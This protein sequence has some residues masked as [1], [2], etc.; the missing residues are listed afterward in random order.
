[1]LEQATIIA[2]LVLAIWYT[3]Q[4]GEI[5]GF[6]QRWSHWKAAPALFDCNVCMTP[7]WGSALYWLIPWDKIKMSE[8]DIYAWPIVVVVAMGINAALNKLSPKDE[9]EI[10]DKRDKRSFFDKLK[11]YLDS[12]NWKKVYDS[13]DSEADNKPYSFEVDTDK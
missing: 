11:E 6:V 13:K 7:W 9:I 8:A 4:E 2:F 12:P 10:I 5:F 1:M 3:F